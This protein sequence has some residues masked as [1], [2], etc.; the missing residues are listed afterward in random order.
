MRRLDANPWIRDPVHIVLFQYSRYAIR[1][2][3][4][5][6][7]DQKNEL[8]DRCESQECLPMFVQKQLRSRIIIC[9][10]ERSVSAAICR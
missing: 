5:S 9:P 7:K 3:I 4:K 2:K 6:N 1:A 8:I 10:S